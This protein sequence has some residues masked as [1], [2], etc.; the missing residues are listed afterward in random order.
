MTSQRGEQVSKISARLSRF[1]TP[2]LRELGH[3]FGFFL[4][5]TRVAR[6]LLKKHATGVAT[7]ALRSGDRLLPAIFASGSRASDSVKPHPS[8][9]LQG[10]PS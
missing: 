3:I 7:E 9:L 8:S 2:M 5:G 10:L 4:L 6:V 1:Q